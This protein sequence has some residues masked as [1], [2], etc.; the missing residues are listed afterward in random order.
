VTTGD[1]TD[2]ERHALTVEAW[3]S[4]QA[5]R[6]EWATPIT[7]SVEDDHGYFEAL[8]AAN[9]RATLD[10]GPKP[11]PPDDE[12]LDPELVKRGAMLVNNQGR[13]PAA[14]LSTP[15]GEPLATPGAA[16]VMVPGLYTRQQVERA[17]DELRKTDPDGAE[18]FGRVY[19]RWADVENYGRKH[20]DLVLGYLAQ[21]GYV[22]TFAGLDYFFRQYL[23]AANLEPDEERRERDEHREVMLRFYVV[24]KEA[25]P[26]PV[27]AFYVNPYPDDEEVRRWAEGW[28][29]ITTPTT[30]PGQHLF[31]GSPVE[32]LHS[33]PAHEAVRRALTMP[34]DWKR[35]RVGLTDY[36]RA[37]QHT[38]ARNDTEITV[39]LGDGEGLAPAEEGVT[40]ELLK[41]L[42]LQH[43]RLYMI[44]CA[45]LS[46]IKPGSDFVEIHG[47][48]LLELMGLAGRRDLSRH[49]K[50]ARLLAWVDD[51]D[52]FRLW[53]RW[54][55]PKREVR[56]A[57]GS[58]I[59]Q[60]DRFVVRQPRL[61]G[62]GGEAELAA[63]NVTVGAGHYARQF[64]SRH[65]E[66]LATRLTKSVL[67]IDP[68]HEPL[69]SRLAIWAS[70]NGYREDFVEVRRILEAILPQQ[71][72]DEL[73]DPT[74]PTKDTLQR[75]TLQGL[76]GD[77]VQR[78][79]FANAWSAALRRLE[80]LGFGI[81]YDAKTYPQE[82]RPAQAGKGYGRRPRGYL[83]R[84]MGARVR[85]TLKEYTSAPLPPPKGEDR[86]LFMGHELREARKAA[87]LSLRHLANAVGVDEALIRRWERNKATP[88]AKYHKALTTALPSFDWKP[89]R[90][91]RK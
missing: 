12:D 18:A 59:F 82:L 11:E 37:Y 46:R 65:G 66:A 62:F 14:P 70:F 81:D 25:P 45:A 40:V 6:R 38:T 53:L 72:N 49:E 8:R 56:E 28:Q 51:L 43:A 48:N 9:R 22:S 5:W 77:R 61:P 34:G 78:H 57:G 83:D 10:L 24:P 32:R 41:R 74:A 73:R 47:D 64:L 31:V 76:E 13:T 17:V 52:A 87:G 36:P 63:F 7:N 29:P 60:L 79:H 39:Y 3:R 44:F 23:R 58:R 50:I 21:Q 90:G 86:D 35:T 55:G 85:F 26:C 15:T 1:L 75:F 2:A 91:R 27:P 71:E 67:E 20:D 89:S 4:W 54:S 33:N 88:A 16:A 68:Y 84:L 19:G 42:G 30:V 69:T 80:R